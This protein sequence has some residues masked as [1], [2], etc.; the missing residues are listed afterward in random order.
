MKEKPMEQ[1]LQEILEIRKKM[2]DLG[3]DIT[4]ELEQFKI[5]CNEYI[6]KG[7]A[8]SRSLKLYELGKKITYNFPKN[9]INVCNVNISE[10]H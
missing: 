7:I 6:K 4:S 5:D 2:F 1:R 9:T 3:M 10:L 8:V